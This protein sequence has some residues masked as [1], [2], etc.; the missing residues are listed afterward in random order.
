MDESEGAGISQQAQKEISFTTGII[1]AIIAILML[2]ILYLLLKRTYIELRIKKST[3][4]QYS[5]R[6]FQD[7]LVYLKKINL[8]MEK[9]ETMR[10]FWHKVKYV[11]EE[12]YQNGDDILA[13]LE[14]I[15]YGVEE[16]SDIERA[17]LEEYRKMLK[18]F[19]TARLGNIKAFISYYI[20][21][22]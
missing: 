9:E 12:A 14:K 6:Y 18:K 16:V 13:L 1:L 4:K 5:A 11:L 15:R 20:V 10:E 8:R 22:L 19:V 2:R 7:V 17:Q 21:G 3:G